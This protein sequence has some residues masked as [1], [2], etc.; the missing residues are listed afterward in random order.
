MSEGPP[1][2]PKGGP[3]PSAVEGFSTRG[4]SVKL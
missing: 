3:A 4:T 2:L 1:E